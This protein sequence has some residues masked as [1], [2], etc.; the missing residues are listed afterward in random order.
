M[1][2]DNCISCGLP[3]KP[4]KYNPNK[5]YCSV[6]CGRKYHYL[7]N[8]EKE[9]AQ[10]KE[11]YSKHRESE[12]QKNKEYREQNRELFEWYHNKIRFNG[13]KELI[14]NRDGNKCIIC[15][16]TKRITVHHIDGT[17]NHNAKKEDAKKINNSLDNLLT[18][19]GSCHTKLHHWQR[20]NNYK[21]KNI[22]EIKDWKG[23]DIVD[24]VPELHYITP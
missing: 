22:K 18:M 23:V 19:C 12:I 2:N 11:W 9:R 21:C 15:N 10:C 1:K 14:I 24:G 5:K 16:S 13:V 17:G 20:R 3:I 6:E 8:I 7:V 4:C